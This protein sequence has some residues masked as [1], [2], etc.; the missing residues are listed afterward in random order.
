MDVSILG[1]EPERC[2]RVCGC[3]ELDCS[4]CVART[5]S[6]C[7]WVAEDLCSACWPLTPD[8]KAELVP[9][10]V[11]LRANPW[12]EG[13]GRADG[14]AVAV[15]RAVAV[16]CEFTGAVQIDAAG[17]PRVVVSREF[18]EYV[19]RCRESGG[20]EFE[21]PAEL[22]CELGWIG[23][24]EMRLVLL[25]DGLSVPER[26]QR[27]ALEQ[28]RRIAALDPERASRAL[29]GRDPA[30]LQLHAEHAEPSRSVRLAHARRA[31]ARASFPSDHGADAAGGALAFERVFKL[32]SYPTLRE[33]LWVRINDYAVIVGG[34]DSLIASAAVERVVGA[35]MEAAVA[36]ASTAAAA[37]PAAGHAV[38]RPATP[39]PADVDPVDAALAHLSLDE[40]VRILLLRFNDQAPRL[41]EIAA[42]VR[43][44]PELLGDG[45]RELLEK[46]MAGL[47]AGVT[48]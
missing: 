43:Q 35:L 16:P 18:S 28:A 19:R 39:T 8:Y 15:G 48:P 17:L 24:L 47:G 42:R 26:S 27:S 46:F 38:G 45:V 7:F 13:V 10:L 4:Q 25:P 29:M 32:Q 44:Q 9:E 12:G 41:R 2:C 31:A 3:T 37:M 40:Q 36:V 6:P 20:T 21:L 23:P 5:G 33:H 1:A 11:P 34:D 22:G 30:E 14:A